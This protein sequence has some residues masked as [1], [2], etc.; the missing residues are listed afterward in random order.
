[1]TPKIEVDLNKAI[2]KLE[3]AK[4]L[5]NKATRTVQQAEDLLREWANSIRKEQEH[6]R[7][8]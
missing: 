6:A 7:K 4:Q 5:T 1:M 2:D 3:E 8:R